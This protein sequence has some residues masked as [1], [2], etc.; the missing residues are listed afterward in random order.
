MTNCQINIG[1]RSGKLWIVQHVFTVKHT[2]ENVTHILWTCSLTKRFWKD[3][4]DFCSRNIREITLSLN[5]VLYRVED[6]TICNIIFIAKTFVYNTRIREDKMLFAGSL[7]I[8]LCY[9]LITD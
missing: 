8:I 1:S 6:I 9:Y 5:D 4:T 7:C 2:N 3:F